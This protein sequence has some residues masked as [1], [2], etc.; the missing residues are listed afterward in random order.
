LYVIDSGTE[1]VRN[2]RT[3]AS[4]AVKWA[5][6]VRQRINS[7]TSIPI[8]D[9]KNMVTEAENLNINCQE[10]RTLRNAYRTTRGWIGR[11]KKIDLD[12]GSSDINIITGLLRE[13]E[14]FLVSSNDHVTK[15]KQ[16]VCGYCICR[17]PYDGFMIGCDECEEW[18]HGLCIGISESQAEK[19]EKYIC[20]R[21]SIKKQYYQFC[22]S[23]ANI[24][25][26]WCDP[27][28]LDKV[29]QNEGNKL[30]RRVRERKREILKVREEIESTTRLL[31]NL[32]PDGC[33]RQTTGINAGE[34]VAECTDLP[35]NANVIDV[36]DSLL[37]APPT[38]IP[39]LA[40][41][42]FNTIDMTVE[43]KYTATANL[44]GSL[45]DG[46]C[47]YCSLYSHLS[48]SSHSS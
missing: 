16:A 18:Y 9:A 20:L 34:T 44:N 17:R 36:H 46:K 26:K 1:T 27:K 5:S 24:I 3:R 21:C 13:H 42:V 25:R 22:S 29:R 41:R 8:E 35:K 10:L 19:F 32:S 48:D 45:V 40:H 38:D 37:T 23:I 43:Q 33:S 14:G 6:S 2:F 28:E 11:L 12:L 15:L 31:E 39:F 30:Q 7:G 47:S 4:S